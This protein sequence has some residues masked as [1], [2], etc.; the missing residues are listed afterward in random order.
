M[1]RTDS[2]RF[3]LPSPSPL[4]NSLSPF[5]RTMLTYFYRTIYYDV[6]RAGGVV[7]Y[8]R[9]SVRGFCFPAEYPSKAFGQRGPA[10]SLSRL[11]RARCRFMI[12]ALMLSLPA[13]TGSHSVLQST[14][15]EATPTPASQPSPAATETPAASPASSPAAA[16]AASPAGSQK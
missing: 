9:Q 14:E 12:I 1:S 7:L 11:L 6:F 8:A 3:D 16:Q 4:P 10:S 15:P 13:V 2:Y 5:R